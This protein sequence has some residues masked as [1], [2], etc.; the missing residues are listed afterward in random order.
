MI[1][2]SLSAGRGIGGKADV[3]H[4]TSAAFGVMGR[5]VMRR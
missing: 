2:R 1:V 5:C 4:R 3:F